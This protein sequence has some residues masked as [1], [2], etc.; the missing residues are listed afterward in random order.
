MAKPGHSE[1][2]LGTTVDLCGLDP[3]TVADPAFGL[4]RE[5]QWLESNAARFGFR[6]SYTPQNTRQ[7]GYVPEPWHYRYIGRKSSVVSPGAIMSCLEAPRSWTQP[8][9][10]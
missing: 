5:G 4:T 10:T 9:T 3:A 8:V 1:H 2:Q 7:T 6:L